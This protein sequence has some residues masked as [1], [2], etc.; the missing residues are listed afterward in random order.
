ME[1]ALALREEVPIFDCI[2]LLFPPS[3]S[4]I[5]NGSKIIFLNLLLG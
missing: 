2:G 4:F 1:G 5:S 3:K